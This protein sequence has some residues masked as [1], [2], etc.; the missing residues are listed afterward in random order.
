MAGREVGRGP[1]VD[2]QEARVADV[3]SEQLVGAL[4]DQRDHRCHQIGRVGG[5]HVDPELVLELPLQVALGEHAVAELHELAVGVVERRHR[6]ALR[7]V[8]A[9]EIGGRLGPDVVGEGEPGTGQVEPRRHRDPVAG[10]VGVGA[11]E[12]HLATGGLGNLHETGQLLVAMSTRRRRSSRR[13]GS[14][15]AT[16]LDRLVVEH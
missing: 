4:R 15:E 9:P 16:Q 8:G 13:P 1:E 10:V 5:L 11:D 14:A 2:G 12:L 6:E 3:A 7:A